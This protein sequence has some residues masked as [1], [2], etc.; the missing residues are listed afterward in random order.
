MVPKDSRDS[1][2]TNGNVHPGGKGK[3]KAKISRTSS[4]TSV[5]DLTP[6]AVDTGIDAVRRI[7][8]ILC[9]MQTYSEEINNVEDI[10]GLCIDQQTQIDELNTM[11]TELTFRKDREMDRLRHENDAYQANEREFEREREKLAGEQASMGATQKAMQS[12]VERQKEKDINKAKQKFSDE[13]KARVKQT[14]EELEKKI[15][16]LETDKN[17]LKDAIKTLEE[18]NIRAQKD[19]NQQKESL[20]L[21]K[22]TSQSHIVRLESEL[23]QIN[24]AS[25][26]SPQ[27]AEF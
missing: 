3:A 8:K 24:L 9:F 17:G 11:V 1:A 22:R 12:E 13:A 7:S 23:R 2:G 27:T 25:I 6:E 26:V 14:R 5:R 18:K 19:F 16:A 10:Y 20:E 21:D 15:Q 4:N